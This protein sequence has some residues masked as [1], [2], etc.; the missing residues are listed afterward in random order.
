MLL[1]QALFTALAWHQADSVLVDLAYVL[2]VE[3]PACYGTV[4]IMKQV[5]NGADQVSAEVV[6]VR[7]P[8]WCGLCAKQCG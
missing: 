2:F 8:Q 7:F 1:L 3:L 4:E 5:V 6:A